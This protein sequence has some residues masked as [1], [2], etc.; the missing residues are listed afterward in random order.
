[1]DIQGADVIVRSSD[2]VDFRVQGAALSLFSPVFADILSIPQ[3]ESS[4]GE[5]PVVSVSEDR[6]LSLVFLRLRIAHY[7]LAR[8]ENIL[9]V[10]E[11]YGVTRVPIEIIEQ[12]TTH[13]DTQPVHTCAIACR[14]SLYDVANQAA[15]ATFK[16]EALYVTDLK[17]DYLSLMGINQY[18]HLVHYRLQASK[19]AADAVETFPTFDDVDTI[20]NS[21]QVYIPGSRASRESCDCSERMSGWSYEELNHEELPIYIVPWLQVLKRDLESALQIWS[22]VDTV[23]ADGKLVMEAVKMPLPFQAATEP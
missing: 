17:P 3:P 2:N 20:N 15:R 22:D 4:N 7:P 13:I 21:M 5:L 9:Q 23:T 19:V 18:Q 1:M 16:N 11:K 6:E 10:L 8:L 12:F 14:Y